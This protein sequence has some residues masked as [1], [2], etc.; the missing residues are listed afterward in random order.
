MACCL[1]TPNHY[2]DQ[3]W[4][5]I[6]E[7]LW[8]SASHKM[9][10]ISTFGMSFTITNTSPSG[11]WVAPFTSQ[12]RKH[13]ERDGVSNH[14]HLDYLLNRL[15][16]CRSKKTSKLRVIDLCAVKST[17]TGEFPAQKASNAEKVSIWWRHH[18]CLISCGGHHQHRGRTTTWSALDGA[19]LDLT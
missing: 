17:V 12:F 8:H 18:G 5:I 11:Q 13:N 2:M 19:V 15:F 7:V 10:K 3:C 16:K 1:M 14:W 9:L 6:S 4:L